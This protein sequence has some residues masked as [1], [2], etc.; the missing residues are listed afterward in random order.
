MAI[1]NRTLAAVLAACLGCIVFLRMGEALGAAYRNQGYLLL[2][3][4][5][6]SSSP[7][8]SAA[9]Q[10]QTLFKTALRLNHADS[11]AVRGQGMSLAV[12]GDRDGASAV[13]RASDAPQLAFGHLGDLAREAAR[14][15]EAEYW[16]TQALAAAPEDSGLWRSM[17]LVYD[18]QGR[19]AQARDAYATGWKFD[20]EANAS[21][22]VAA[23]IHVGE[24]EEAERI[25]KLTLE[26]I[27]VSADRGLWWQALGNLLRSTGRPAEAIGVYEAGLVEY[28]RNPALRVGLGRAYADAG[29]ATTALNEFVTASQ[30]DQSGAAAFAAAE[31]LTEERR[32]AEAWPWFERALAANSNNPRW[33]VVY[34]TAARAAKD[35]ERALRVGEQALRRFPGNGTIYHQIAVAYQQSGQPQQASTAIRKALDLTPEPGAEMLVRAGEIFA[36]AG[37]VEEAQSA[38]ERALVLEPGSKRAAMGLKALAGEASGHE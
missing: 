26:S 33:F 11:A 15:E 30:Q 38:F 16:Y 17:G 8:A 1:R 34:L 5:L 6:V 28:R 35:Y 4:A 32:F 9:R 2:D 21:L 3:R 20:R 12:A 7:K 18:K 31:L 19:W 13:L 10:A 29:D 25:L 37:S 36:A 22:L 14:L 27:P 23:L 24:P